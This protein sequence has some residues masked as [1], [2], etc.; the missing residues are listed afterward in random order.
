MKLVAALILLSSLAAGCLSSGGQ[1]DR[2]EE[3]ARRGQ[4]NSRLRRELAE[5]QQRMA[6]QQEQI[7]TLLDL[8]S[9]RLER[10][11]HV[12]RIRLGRFTSGYDDDGEPGYDGVKVFLQ[13][14]DGSGSVLKAAGEVKIQL[15]DLAA[16]EG[17]TELG[18]YQFDLDA[19]A[20]RWFSGAFT[21]HFSFL[22]PWRDRRPAGKE[23]TVRA[24]FTD[25]L[26]GKTFTAQRLCILDAP[27]STQPADEPN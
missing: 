21:Y 26:T 24:V 3:E 25:Y 8:G 17:S 11:F 7:A 6:D 20:T 15:V 9:H 14:I 4:E 5:A 1:G 22:C 23:V 16:P 2:Q 19:V 10:I 13:P 27:P 12:E 18:A